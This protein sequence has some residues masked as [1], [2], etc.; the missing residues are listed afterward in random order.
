[1]NFVPRLNADGIAG[2]R[3]YYNDNPFYNAG[4]GMPNC[5]AYA[6]GRFW[7]ESPQGG[8]PRLSTGNAE[9]WYNY[10]DGYPRGNTPKVGAI[11][12]LSGGVSTGHVCIVEEVRT[13][14][15]ILTSNSGYNSTY[16]WTEV[17]S[18][19][20]NH[21]TNGTFQGFIYNPNVTNTSATPYVVSA[22]CGCWWRESQVNPAV[23]ESLIP[24]TFD[25]E[26]QYDNI[27]GYGLGQWTNV[28]TPY[29]RLYNL[30]TWVN[31]NGF[32]DGDGDGQLAY[33]P[34]ENYWSRT[35]PRLGYTT[36]TQF[37]ESNSTSLDD[38]VYDFLACWEGVEGN[39]YSQR[40]AW[41]RQCYDY[42]QL[43]QTDDP[44]NYSWISGNRYLS[45]AETLNNVMC[46]WF[47]FNNQQPVPPLPPIESKK[48]ML[49]VNK[50]KFMKRRGLIWR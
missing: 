9:D 41:A 6:W 32:T 15:D 14:G 50:R 36:L 33:I 27:G 42:I 44:N 24:S 23:W 4:Y 25:H 20:Y 10:N 29:G 37:L 39:A 35:S 40:L 31:N 16:F 8:T 34:V 1:M 22:M 18:P 5:T 21:P 3:Y 49:Y 17:Y 7:E 11:L 12:C 46:V 2:S 45:E 19:P 43:H 48:F 47:W 26:Y 38:L 30:H 28:G 13:N